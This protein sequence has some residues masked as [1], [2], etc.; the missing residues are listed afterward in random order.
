MGNYMTVNYIYYI[1]REFIGT[2][3]WDDNGEP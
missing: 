1:Y 2:W 3:N